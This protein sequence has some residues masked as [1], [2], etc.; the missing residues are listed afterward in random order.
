MKTQRIKIL[1]TGTFKDRHGTEVNIDNNLIQTIV[2]NY[3]S[4]PKESLHYAPL[5]PL[6]HD[7]VG[8]S[9]G[10]VKSLEYSDGAMYANVEPTPELIEAVRT[11]RLKTVS[12]GLNKTRD[13]LDHV[14]ILGSLTPAIK[15]LE[16]LEFSEDYA[17]EFSD[18]EINNLL[19]F[20]EAQMPPYLIALRDALIAKLNVELGTDQGAKFNAIFDEVVKTMQGQFP[21]VQTPQPPPQNPPQQ[22]PSFAQFSET[23]EG[24]AFLL[25]QQEMQNE[26]AKLKRENKK[27]EFSTFLNDKLTKITTA[28][29]DKA[30]EIMLNLVD[31]EKTEFS[32]DS[33]NLSGV[34]LFKSFVE[35]L[36]DVVP[37]GSQVQFSSNEES[38]A[39]FDSV[40]DN[41][42]KKK[43]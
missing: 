13:N 34:E 22:S 35:K 12:A 31:V 41:Y 26:M 5:R 36:P 18:T 20:N 21:A 37:L 16:Y 17:I 11:N 2:K 43:R 24:K 32:E 10:F 29:K 23:E 6:N 15:G 4:Q 1:K 19:N 33:K 7:N 38:E 28:N 25:K 42:N 9:A 39:K 3:N 27:L 40:I 8:F 14:A 30:V